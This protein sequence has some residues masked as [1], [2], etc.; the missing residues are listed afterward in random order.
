MTDL[1]VV[2]LAATF[3]TLVH[4]WETVADAA[5]APA[6]VPT[7]GL[8]RWYRDGTRNF[9]WEFDPTSAVWKGEEVTA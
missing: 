4:N 1:N 7:T 6:D 3:D 8:T 5:I 2:V 9:I